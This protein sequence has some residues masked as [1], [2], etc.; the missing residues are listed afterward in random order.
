MS[1]ESEPLRFRVYRRLLTLAL[2]L[3][4]RTAATWRIRDP[5]P[6]VTLLSNQD[7]VVIVTRHAMLAQLLGLAAAR[8]RLGVRR[9]F[10]VILSKSPDGA[11]LAEAL[12][13]VGIDYS[14]GVANRAL[15]V[16]IDRGEVAIVAADGP[17]GPRGHVH[18][19]ALW[20]AD[21]SGAV[22][23][24]VALRAT[25]ALTLPTW[26]RCV[27]PLPFARIRIEAEILSVT[28][29]RDADRSAAQAALDRLSS[30]KTTDS[31]N[32]TRDG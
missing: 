1:N 7:R 10:V 20:L 16:G 31:P 5:E 29:D 30:I 18:P 24:L 32:S 4:R 21:R 6:A 3:L 2:F 28:G 15:A 17:I 19:G 25:P 23:L 26:D 14:Y 9:P 22:V 12:R 8:G 13:R 27:V 11:L